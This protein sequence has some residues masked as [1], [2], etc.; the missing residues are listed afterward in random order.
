MIIAS[1]TACVIALS[2]GGVRYPWVSARVLAP[3]VLGI[4]GLCAALLYE[5]RFAKEPL[6]SFRP[7]CT[8]LRH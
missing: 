8:V 5:A 2:W 6:V 1:S 7:V 4:C 3:L